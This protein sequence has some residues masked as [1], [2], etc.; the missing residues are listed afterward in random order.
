MGN[1]STTLTSERRGHSASEG[2][3]PKVEDGRIALGLSRDEQARG[4]G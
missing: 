1:T 2:G 4:R 3:A